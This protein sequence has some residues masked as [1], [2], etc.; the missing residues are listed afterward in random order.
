MISGGEA[1]GSI[2]STATV[3]VSDTVG[4][5]VSSTPSGGALVT[6]TVGGKVNASVPRAVGA[7][8]AVAVGDGVNASVLRIV[9]RSVGASVEASMH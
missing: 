4:D 5:S 7:L 3:S 2:V 6:E 8:V 9:P 1:V